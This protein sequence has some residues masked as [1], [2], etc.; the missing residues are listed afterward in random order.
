MRMFEV[1][2]CKAVHRRPRAPVQFRE[3]FTLTIGNADQ[4]LLQLVP[5]LRRGV[6]G[7]HQQAEHKLPSPVIH[8]MHRKDDL[9]HGISLFL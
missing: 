2:K 5:I 3:G 8:V 7:C 1:G 9:L 6:F 4:Q